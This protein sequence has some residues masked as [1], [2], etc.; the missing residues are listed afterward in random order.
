MGD[1]RR[2]GSVLDANSCGTSSGRSPSFRCTRRTGT[3]SVREPAGWPRGPTSIRGPAASG[4]PSPLSPAVVFAT[5]SR[6]R[7]QPGP[8]TYPR[9]W[10]RFPRKCRKSPGVHY[11]RRT[12]I[13]KEKQREKFSSADAL[14]IANRTGWI[15]IAEIRLVDE[16]AFTNSQ[17]CWII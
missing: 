1:G 11:S 8:R 16:R 12:S 3:V 14:G 2:S 15:D 13:N 4:E 17:P 9:P 6:R 7:E 10:R 5:W